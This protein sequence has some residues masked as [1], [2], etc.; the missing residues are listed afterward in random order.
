MPQN[1]LYGHFEESKWVDG[2]VS[3]IFRKYEK[4]DGVSQWILFD[5]PIDAIWVE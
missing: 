3:Q 2:V 4:K 1:E 5:G